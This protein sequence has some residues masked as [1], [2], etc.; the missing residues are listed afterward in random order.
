MAI[1][2]DN[3]SASTIGYQG[4]ATFE[5]TIGEDDETILVVGGRSGDDTVTIDNV[6]YAGVTATQQIRIVSSV[7]D[8]M[9]EIWTLEDPAVGTTNVVVTYSASSIDTGAQAVSFT[10]VT[11]VRG[12]SSSEGFTGTPS[13]GLL[14]VDG[15]LGVDALSG[16]PDM[17][18]DS[19]QI[20][21][22][23]LEGAFGS[24]GMSYQGASSASTTMSW[25]QSAGFETLSAIAL[26]P[27]P[28]A[29]P[30]VVDTRRV[31]L[32]T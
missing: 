25:T 10:G 23:V 26:V 4:T 21:L 16:D 27:A 14:T 20:G 18:P 9:N 30:P 3:Q 8:I 28:D 6:T 1:S 7:V 17:A 19:P 24:F 29:P 12:A 31:F 2:I 13:V 11:A 15:D 5:H 22:T 32:V